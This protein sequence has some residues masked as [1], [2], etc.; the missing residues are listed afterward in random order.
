MDWIPDIGSIGEMAGQVIGKA[1]NKKFE[2]KYKDKDGN[3]V[4]FKDMAS[5]KSFADSTIDKKV[6]DLK[7]FTKLY[8]P[9]Y[10]SISGRLYDKT[11]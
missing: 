1:M 5:K 4:T 2:V 6:I 9:Y 8:L 7:E 10:S 11:D 3:T